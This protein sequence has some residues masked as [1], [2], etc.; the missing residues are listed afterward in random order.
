VLAL[1]TLKTGERILEYKGETVHGARRPRST[2][3]RMLRYTRLFF[4]LEDG[5][6]IDGVVAAT[7]HAG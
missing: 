5:R 7:A 3:A 4:W 6:V 1:R 2:G